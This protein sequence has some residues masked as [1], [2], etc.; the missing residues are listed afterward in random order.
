MTTRS[1]TPRSPLLR[2]IQLDYAEEAKRA[3]AELAHLPQDRRVTRRGRPISGRKPTISLRI[4]AD[5][6]AWFKAQGKG[7]QTRIVEVLEHERQ[8]TARH[9]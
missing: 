7:Y 5:L 8:R 6:L 2:R 4:P 9:G 3:E 1:R